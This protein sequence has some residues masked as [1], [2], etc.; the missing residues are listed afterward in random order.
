MYIESLH[1]VVFLCSPSFQCVDN[2]RP[3]WSSCVD[4][5]SAVYD[6]NSIVQFNYFLKLFL[7]LI[8]LI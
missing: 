1:G 7:T 6:L 5:N 3:D 8:N 4:F 2:Q